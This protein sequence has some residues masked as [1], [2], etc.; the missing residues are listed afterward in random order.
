MLS[1]ELIEISKARL[2]S[3]EDCLRDAKALA[4]SGRYKALSNRSYYAVF[5]AMRAVLVLDEID[6]KK[7][8]GIISEFRRKYIKPGIFDNAMSE[9]ISKLFSARTSCDYDD[10][11]NVSPEDALEQLR[12]AEEF[13][14]KIRAY[15]SCQL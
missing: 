5:H 11:F 7:H 6:S 10:F 9:T 15:L 1:D 4:D 13:V 14:K 3:A 2:A 12:E 8:S